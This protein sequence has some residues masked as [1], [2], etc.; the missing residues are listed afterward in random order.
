MEDLTTTAQVSFTATRRHLE[1]LTAY[2]VVETGR[3]GKRNEYGL[4]EWAREKLEL[5]GRIKPERSDAG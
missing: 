2:G 3:A 1:D 5:L 4:S